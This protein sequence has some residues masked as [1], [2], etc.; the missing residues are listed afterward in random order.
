MNQTH[1]YL[2]KGSALNFSSLDPSRPIKW[3][4]R[5][6]LRHPGERSTDRY[7]CRGDDDRDVGEDRGLK[8]AMWPGRDRLECTMLG[9][10]SWVGRKGGGWKLPFFY[11]DL[12]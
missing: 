4:R 12:H 10:E 6:W 9:E 3:E 1:H 5:T 8:R 7:A 11:G 2:D